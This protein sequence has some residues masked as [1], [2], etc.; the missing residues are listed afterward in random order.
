MKIW[1]QFLRLDRWHSEYP[2]VE[3]VLRHYAR[4]VRSEKT[5]KNFSMIL[6]HFCKF[7]EKNP[8]DLVR[9]SVEG[10]SRFCQAYTDSLMDKNYSIRCSNSIRHV[11]LEFW[12][13][14]DCGG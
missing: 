3:R 12:C 4:R 5:R 11:F 6:T 2:S 7:A 13:Y 1:E 14:E 8:D 9:L 10:A